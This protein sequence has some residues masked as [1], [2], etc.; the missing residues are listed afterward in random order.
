L[1]RIGNELLKTAQTY[2]NPCLVK[3]FNAVFT[4]GIY[5]QIWSEGYITGFFC[6]VFYCITTIQFSLDLVY[7]MHKSREIGVS[8]CSWNVGGLISV[9]ICSWN[10]GGLISNHHNKT[11]DPLLIKQIQNCDMVLLTETHVGYTTHLL[12]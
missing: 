6:F 7:K 2:L 12:I 4:S 10:V 11:I 3:L 5:P 1:D 8:I 9:S